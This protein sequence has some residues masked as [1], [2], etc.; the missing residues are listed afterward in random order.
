MTSLG[1]HPGFSPDHVFSRTYFPN[2]YF[3]QLYHIYIFISDIEKYCW[4][5]IFASFFTQVPWSLP[6]IFYSLCFISY[7]QSKHLSSRSHFDSKVYYL[8]ICFS[9]DWLRHLCGYYHR[10]TTQRFLKVF[11]EKWRIRYHFK[12]T[13]SANHTNID[14][15]LAYSGG[16]SEVFTNGSVAKEQRIRGLCVKE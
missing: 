9:L 12:V 11:T 10:S 14:S 7:K 15:M 6:Q 16:R 5:Q 3:F 4:I 2:T 8:Y 13:L 1:N